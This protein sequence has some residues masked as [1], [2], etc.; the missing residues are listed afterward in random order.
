MMFLIPFFTVF[1]L[2]ATPSVAE[3]EEGGTYSCDTPNQSLMEAVGKQLQ[4][5]G[6]YLVFIDYWEDEYVK[7]FLWEYYNGIR[8]ID[9]SFA[10]FKMMDDLEEYLAEKP[11]GAVILQDGD[12]IKFV[13]AVAGTG[14]VV[15][16]LPVP[17]IIFNAIMAK[18]KR[19]VAEAS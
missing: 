11:R 5:P 10:K 7:M 19:N 4:E 1:L 18:L 6:N 13:S 9:M 16:I 12:T 2:M 15:N 3:E 14:C 8:D 17:I